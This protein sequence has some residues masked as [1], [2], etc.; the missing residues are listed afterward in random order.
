MHALQKEMQNKTILVISEKK[1]CLAPHLAPL[2]TNSAG[3]KEETSMTMWTV[4][5]IKVLLDILSH[6]IVMKNHFNLVGGVVSK[7]K[8]ELE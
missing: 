7:L 4:Q 3:N 5:S 1:K 6:V 8:A 2:Y